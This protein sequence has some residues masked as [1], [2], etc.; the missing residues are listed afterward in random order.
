MVCTAGAGT[1]FLMSGNSAYDPDWTAVGQQPEGFDEW[2]AFYEEYTVLKSTM[3]VKFLTASDQPSAN[4]FE[5]AIAPR[6]GTAS[7]LVATGLDNLRSTPY[8]VHDEIAGPFYPKTYFASMSTAKIYG[9]PESAITAEDTY[10]GTNAADPAQE[11]TWQVAAKPV[12]GATSI[13]VYAYV[14]MKFSCLF[15]SRRRVTQ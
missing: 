9:K 1:Y 7:V 12:D 15:H 8:S 13:T 10:S 5:I 11:W 4:V 3:S 14:T 6:A 2:M